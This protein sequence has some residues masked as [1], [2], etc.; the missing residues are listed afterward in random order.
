MCA[1]P[2]PPRHGMSGMSGEGIR[3]IH[4]YFDVFSLRP[5]WVVTI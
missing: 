1:V 5:L 2:R 3:N 4:S